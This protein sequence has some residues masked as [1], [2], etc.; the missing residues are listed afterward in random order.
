M[1]KINPYYIADLC[2]NYRINGTNMEPHI[3]IKAF[4]LFI[5]LEE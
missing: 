4:E 2:E 1:Y 5:E 3:L